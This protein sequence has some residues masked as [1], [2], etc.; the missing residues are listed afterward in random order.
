MAEVLHRY[1]EPVVA[2]EGIDYRAQICGRERE[3]G[4]WEGWIEFLPTG[5]GTPLRSARESTQPNRQDL[6]Y[7]SRGLTP[8]YLEGALERTLSLPPAVAPTPLASPAF[9]GPAPVPER[10]SP[11]VAILDPFSVHAKG[12]D[13]LR[14]ELRA[15]EAWHLRNIV[16]AYRLADESQIDLEALD[17]SQ[18][19][20]LIV[21]AVEAREST[22]VP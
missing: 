3:D 9:S 4:M 10:G 17:R 20:D 2:A 15:L 5:D 19:A 18:L 7:W 1:D 8:V 12:R 16:R 13:L 6:L 14:Q 21:A 11:P 22:R